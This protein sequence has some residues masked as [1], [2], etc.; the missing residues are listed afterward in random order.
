MASMK[1]FLLI[2]ALFSIHTVHGGEAYMTLCGGQSGCGTVDG[3]SWES[4]GIAPSEGTKCAH[5]P[6]NMYII[7]DTVCSH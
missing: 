6:V 7:I 2:G 5:H 1:L 3:C 4:D